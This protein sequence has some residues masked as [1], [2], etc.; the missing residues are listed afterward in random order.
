MRI[1]R[2]AIYT[3]VSTEHGLEQ[4][5]NSLDN[6]REASE[7]YVKSQ[8]H[9]G[10]RA[11]SARYDDA[12]FS[13]GSMDR[14]A[15]QRLLSDIRASLIDV[16][17]VYKVDRLTRSLSDF[18]KLV[19]LFDQNG[20]SFVS[21]TQAFNTTTSMGRLTLNVLLSFAQFERELTGERIRDKI[22]ASKRKGLWMGGQV[23]L[24]YRVR[25]RKLVM[26][27]EEAAT[28]RLMFERYLSLGSLP[29]LQR[30]LRQAGIVSRRRRLSSDAVVGGVPFTNGPL[31]H[32]LRNRVYLG[33]INHKGQSHPGEHEPIIEHA[34]FEAVQ[35]RLDDNRR[36]KRRCHTNSEALLQGRIFDDRGNRMTP[37]YAVKN[38]AR[39]RYYVS[40]VLAQG[41]RSEAGSVPRVPAPE[42]EGIVLK[43]LREA[44]ATPAQHLSERELVHE[45]LAKLVLRTGRLE[46]WLTP[47]DDAQP[48][49]LD[50]PWSAPA[51]RRKREIIGPPAEPSQRRPM[52]A[53][54]RARLLEGI[55][56]ARLWLDELIA[57]TFTSTAEIALH[58]RCS[59]RAVRTTL[60]LAFLAPAIV[61]AAVE[62]RLPY[63]LTASSFSELP[64]LWEEQLQRAR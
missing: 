59:E 6:Q 10:W 21:V 37:S 64:M 35:A 40:C 16:V 49:R 42:I 58:E 5:F 13:G 7:A 2:C 51:S 53:D 30:E 63:G 50:L 56:K 62:S 43:A 15:L 12:G 54:S 24:G 29:A 1:L 28:I 38:G 3:R 19:E 41:R 4:E 9:E 39:Y 46:I 11:L 31:A 27:K 61:R 47:S 57:G 60:S 20:V 45:R 23:P 44:D 22:A 33:K 48:K 34:L 18:A 55:A 8:A 52:K 14:P 17:V 26:H 25:D 32:I 36:G